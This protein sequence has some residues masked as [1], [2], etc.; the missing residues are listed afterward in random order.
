MWSVVRFRA[1]SVCL[2]HSHSYPRELLRTRDNGDGQEPNERTMEFWMRSSYHRTLGACFVSH[3]R[4][5]I[6]HPFIYRSDLFAE[7]AR[8]VWK[9]W[10]SVR[11]L[12]KT[13]RY[14]VCLGPFFERH[15]IVNC[16]Q[17]GRAQNQIT[18]SYNPG[19]VVEV[20]G[21][22]S[23]EQMRITYAHKGC[24]GQEKRKGSFIPEEADAYL[25]IN[26]YS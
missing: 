23:C 8:W 15:L 14:W 1:T 24:R 9:L 19:G 2:R 13:M 21:V 26:K 6:S 11:E 20:S 16:T 10:V 17:T 25:N 3:F 18:T 5:V 4:G 7:K 22:Q 12:D